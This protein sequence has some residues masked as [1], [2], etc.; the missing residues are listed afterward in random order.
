MIENLVNNL[1]LY[2]EGSILLAFM[3]AYL[4]GV[5]ISFTPCTYPLIPVTVGIIGAQSSSSKLRGFSLSMFYVAGLAVSYSILGG[6]AALSGRI[7]GQ[8]QTTPW[9]YF[10]MGNL[11][12]IM[13]LAMLD[14]FSISLPVSQKLMKFTGGSGNKGFLK[15]FIIGAISGFVIGPCTA[16]ALAVLLGYVALKTNVLLGMT[17]LFVFAFG[18]GTLLVIVGTF[19]GV[20]AALPKSGEWMTKI[21][22]VFGL[23][24]IGAAEY[25]LYT[26]GVLSI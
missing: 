13:G 24:L 23:I 15:I 19:A 2:I 17:L 1:S 11:C 16:P 4:G 3:A 21:K 18:M 25:F 20:I 6:V 12:L 8:L 10:I 5:I 22:F 26:A 14:V 9:T 7:F